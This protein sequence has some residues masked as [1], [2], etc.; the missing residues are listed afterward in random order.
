MYCNTEIMTGDKFKATFTF[1]TDEGQL[2]VLST[3]EI[4]TPEALAATLAANAVAFC[5]NRYGA[6]PVDMDA[7]LAGTIQ[8]ESASKTG[9]MLLPTRLGYKTKSTPNGTAV[10]FFQGTETIYNGWF[11]TTRKP[12]HVF[13]GTY[14]YTTLT[15]CW[16]YGECVKH[17]AGGMDASMAWQDSEMTVSTCF[18][19]VGEPPGILTAAE[20]S[21]LTAPALAINTINYTKVSSCDSVP[22]YVPK[23]SIEGFDRNMLMSWNARTAWLEEKKKRASDY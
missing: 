16:T 21:E 7:V 11:Q 23:E 18:A 12:A 15:A 9:F 19:P 4:E 17:F 6:E 8:A 3:H 14:A 1:T 22:L 5:K 20:E 13:L 10:D 2:Y